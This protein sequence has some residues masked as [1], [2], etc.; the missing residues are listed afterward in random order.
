[1]STTPKL[2][3]DTNIVLDWLVFNDPSTDMLSSLQQ[4]AQF[5]L[6]THEPAIAELRRVLNYPSLKLDGTRQQS[7]LARYQAMATQANLPDD[8]SLQNLQL[9]PGFPL[10]KDPDDQHFLALAFHTQADALVSKDKALLALRKRAA[11]FGVK[12]CA[13]TQLSALLEPAQ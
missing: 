6:L 2:V 9:P 12:I 10:C 8:F 11:K 13:V 4:A 1:M 5:V 3:L 7:I